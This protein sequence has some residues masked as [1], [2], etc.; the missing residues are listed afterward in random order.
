M[1]YTGVTELKTWVFGMVLL[2]SKL[3]F[4]AFHATP[5]PETKKVGQ[6]ALESLSSPAETAVANS[7]SLFL[8]YGLTEPG[9]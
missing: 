1:K 9:F 5:S 3:P 6:N 2:S 7:P 4:S 8:S